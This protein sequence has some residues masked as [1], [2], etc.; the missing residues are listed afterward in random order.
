M[1]PIVALRTVKGIF[2]ILLVFNNLTAQAQEEDGKKIKRDY[3]GFAASLGMRS[4]TLSSNYAAINNMDVQ[5]GGGALGV[6]WGGKGFQTKLTAGY[7][8]STDKVVHTTDLVQLDLAI[9]IYP[10][11]IIQENSYVIEPYFIA[12]IC[13]NNYKLYGF[14][15]NEQAGT[16]NYSVT[17]EP[18]LGKVSNYNAVFGVGFEINLLDEYEF[19]KIFVDARYSSPVSEKASNVFSE[20]SASSQLNMNVGVAFGTNRF[21]K[22]K[23]RLW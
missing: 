3:F 23:T 7:Y 2:I 5:Q 18:Y 19:C 8:P 12:G 11:Y 20:T 6:L 1:K 21:Y 4:S 15:T 22:N 17:I 10:I 9:N 16:S 14:Y 13:N